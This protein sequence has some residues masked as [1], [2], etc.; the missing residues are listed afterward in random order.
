MPF[1]LPLEFQKELTEGSIKVYKSRLNKLAS[2]GYDNCD[3][4]KKA[5]SKIIDAI[6]DLDNNTQRGILAAISWVIPLPEE[7][8]YKT[9][10]LNHVNPV[11]KGGW[12]KK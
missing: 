8:A 1:Q 4:V 12:P 3:I 7:N 6:K 10:I 2:L 9:Y 11:P 5:P